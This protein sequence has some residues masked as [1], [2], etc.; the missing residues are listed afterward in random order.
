MSPEG[1]NYILVELLTYLV[2]SFLN[3]H[4]GPVIHKQFIKKMKM[5]KITKQPIFPIVL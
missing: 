2:T 5:K 1:T 3:F 4:H